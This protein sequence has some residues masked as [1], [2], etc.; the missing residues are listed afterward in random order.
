MIDLISSQ[1]HIMDLLGEMPVI[2]SSVRI[3]SKCQAHCSFCSS[4]DIRQNQKKSVADEFDLYE[5]ID[6]LAVIGV[7]HL[8]ITGG[9][10]TLVDYLD[11]II[12]HAVSQSMRVVMSS[13]G[14]DLCPELITRLSYAGLDHLQISLHGLK[15]THDRVV[16]VD[17]AYDKVMENISLSTGQIKNVSVAMTLTLENLDNVFDLVEQSLAFQARWVALHPLM[18]L[19][20]AEKQKTPAI[21]TILEYLDQIDRHYRERLAIMLPPALVPSW[22][23]NNQFGSG[24]ICA[25]PDMLALDDD[26]TVA[27]CDGLLS[28]PDWHLGN[29]FS[30]NLN[31]IIQSNSSERWRHL[32]KDP[33]N[34]LTGIC[35]RCNFKSL[36]CGGCRALSYKK[37]GHWHA[38]DIWCQ[39]AFDSGVFPAEA[40]KE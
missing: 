37:N 32:R 6:Q 16:G 28:D 36:C 34:E 10:P 8:F 22:A 20:R 33:L 7:Q 26:G 27:P 11:S 18:P 19:G 40:L 35:L 2:S 15:G 25:F 23:K 9:E 30:N 12:K 14:L 24:Y 21:K 13:N 4:A 39:E 38:P 31:Q 29:L 1:G 3:T 5:W 17:G